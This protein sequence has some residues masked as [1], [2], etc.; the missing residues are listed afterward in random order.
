MQTEPT[1]Q[2][3]IRLPRTTHALLELRRKQ[4]E[5]RLQMPV[6]MSMVIRNI[7]QRDLRADPPKRA[8]K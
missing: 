6:S 1:V 5:K 4:I 2:I 3:G 7:V 8:R